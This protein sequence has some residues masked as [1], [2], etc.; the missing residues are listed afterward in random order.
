[1]ENTI[2]E[3]GPITDQLLETMDAMHEKFPQ[4]KKRLLRKQSNLLI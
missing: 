1:M 4:L 2:V 3:K